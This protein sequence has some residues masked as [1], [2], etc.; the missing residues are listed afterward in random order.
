MVAVKPPPLA[1]P[2]GTCWL[3]VS[4]SSLGEPS[5]ALKEASSALIAAEGAPPLWSVATSASVSARDHRLTVTR[6][7]LR[8]STPVYLE[9]TCTSPL[10]AASASR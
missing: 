7:P 4:P 8:S 9:N 2:A 5:M 6:R 10:N 1:T 3:V